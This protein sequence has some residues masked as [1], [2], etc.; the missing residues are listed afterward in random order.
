MLAEWGSPHHYFRV[1]VLLMPVVLQFVQIPLT[2]DLLF[3][4]LRFVC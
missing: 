3:V 1:Y 4:L 2:G